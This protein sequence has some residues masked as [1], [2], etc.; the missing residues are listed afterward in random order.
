[1]PV[2]SAQDFVRA[3]KNPTK[4]ISGK[5]ILCV[6]QHITDISWLVELLL[7][8]LSINVKI[9]NAYSVRGS[10]R[11]QES[12]SGRSRIFS[13]R[14]AANTCDAD[15]FRRRISNIGQRYS[16]IHEILLLFERLGKMQLSPITILIISLTRDILG[17]RASSIPPKISHVLRSLARKLL[18]R[19]S[20]IS[21]PTKITSTKFWRLL[22]VESKKFLIKFAQI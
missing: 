12:A 5:Q 4:F 18:K 17:R 7:F 21:Q 13:R 6:S 2:F 20:P 15:I 1:M 14:A 8:F 22:N 16:R 9:S 19:R 10:R 3:T 11:T